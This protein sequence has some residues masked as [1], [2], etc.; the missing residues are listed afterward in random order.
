MLIN[1]KIMKQMANTLSDD[2]QNNDEITLIFKE[3]ELFY[4]ALEQEVERTRP[5]KIVF[6]NEKISKDSKLLKK[7]SNCSNGKDVL[8]RISEFILLAPELFKAYQE[9]DIQ[10][11]VEIYGKQGKEGIYV[12]YAASFV[13]DD[14]LDSYVLLLKPYKAN[15]EKIGFLPFLA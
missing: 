13:F 1:G 2:K 14:K 10:K 11:L 7:I 9:K 3:E 15:K 6:K 8:I 12:M 4:L 5:I